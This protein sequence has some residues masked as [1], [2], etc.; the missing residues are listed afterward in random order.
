MDVFESWLKLVPYRYVPVQLFD[1][2][3][4]STRGL[5]ERDW[6]LIGRVVP[7]V[8]EELQARLEDYSQNEL[9]PSSVEYYDF[10]RFLIAL[11]KLCR[12]TPKMLLRDDF[13]AKNRTFEI[14]TAFYTAISCLMSPEL[15][16]CVLHDIKNNSLDM[17]LRLLAMNPL[18]CEGFEEMAEQRL[19]TYE[20]LTKVRKLAIESLESLEGLPKELMARRDLFLQHLRSKIY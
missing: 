16:Q 18:Q 8:I 12:N 17:E 6:V 3:D 1:K 7:K 19:R 5:S 15:I 20:D 10:I 11:G 2:I 13:L 9:D 14:S 4:C